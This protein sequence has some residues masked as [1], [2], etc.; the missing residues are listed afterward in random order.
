MGEFEGGPGTF[1]EIGLWRKA[2][3]VNKSPDL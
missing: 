2:T 1:T 3:E